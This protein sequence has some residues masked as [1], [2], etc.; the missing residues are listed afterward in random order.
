[1]PVYWGHSTIVKGRYGPGPGSFVYARDYSSARELAKELERIAANDDR[2]Q[3][4]FRWKRQSVTMPYQYHKDNDVS[5]LACNIC[6]KVLEEDEQ[7]SIDEE[8]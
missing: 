2:Y 3:S 7:A 5:N 1:M 8:A 4:Y 6:K